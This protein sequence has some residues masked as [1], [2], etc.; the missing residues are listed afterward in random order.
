MEKS[1]II[2]LAMILFRGLEANSCC[3]SGYSC[4]KVFSTERQVLLHGEA[5][6]LETI[7]IQSPEINLSVSSRGLISFNRSGTYKI[8]WFGDVLSPGGIPWTLGFSLDGLVI[9]GS[10]YGHFGHHP[11]AEKIEGSVVLNINAGQVL[12][13]INSSFHPIELIPGGS[14]H[15][16]SSFTVCISLFVPVYPVVLRKELF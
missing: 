2:F 10:I 7:N 14:H 5:I 12:Q 16:L 4:T 1:V 11:G 8:S 15:P 6:R 3:P 13:L 9:F